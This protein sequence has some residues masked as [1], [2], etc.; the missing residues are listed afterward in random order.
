MKHILA[1]ILICLTAAAASAG[2]VYVDDNASN[3]PAP[4][5]PQISDPA[6]DGTLAHPFDAI[7]Q[8]IDATANNDE[9]IILPGTYTGNGNRDIDYKGKPITVRSTNPDDPNTV[10]TTIIDCQGTQAEPHRG[11]YFHTG[12]TEN[13]V[14]KGLTITKG[15]ADKG[16]GILC[17]HSSPMIN[18]CVI[19]R[20]TASNTDLHH[21]GGAIHCYSSH[22][23]IGESI[24]T[25]NTGGGISCREGGPT[26]RECVF[27]HNTT[28]SGG[29]ILSY[30]SSPTIRNCTMRYNQA[31]M[32]GGAIECMEGSPS[33]NN[34]SI[35]ANMAGGGGGITCG[36]GS[37]VTVVNCYVSGNK[38]GMW[39]GGGFYCIQTSAQIISCTIVGN[40]SDQR[41]GGIFCDELGMVT[42]SNSIIRDN[43][44]SAA[45]QMGYPQYP[46]DDF[47]QRVIYVSYSNIQGSKEAV[48]GWGDTHWQDG[49][50]DT[51]PL[52][53][54]PG[55][56]DGDT[57]IDGDYHL[58]SKAGRY[59]PVTETWVLDEE[60]SPCIDA[61]N[62]QSDYTNEPL[63]NGQRSNIGAYANTQHASKTGNCKAYPTG[64]LNKDC[65]VT[66]AD[67][68]IMTTNWLTCNLTPKNAC[69]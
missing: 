43:S 57:W 66:L 3:D 61:G 48:E 24:I 31:T 10:A 34:C 13:S 68:A 36:T 51:N 21:S 38:A 46:D 25:D 65:K 59:N 30:F 54:I 37:N 8:A 56:W 52:F 69:N 53:A 15:Y 62:P 58:K 7:Q 35:V 2:Y 33:I 45:S 17:D 40:R 55:H 16:G 63:Y 41:G 64:D 22:A 29:A 12:E 14:L 60:H 1:I 19:Q 50:I 23:V 9:V 42:L 6:E 39:G 27:T 67:L 26:I 18:D 32:G 49:N 47:T 44:A 20:N 4:G 28:K 5:N 11:F